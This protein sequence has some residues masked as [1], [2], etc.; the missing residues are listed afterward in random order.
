MTETEEKLK[1]DSGAEPTSSGDEKAYPTGLRLVIILATLML[2]TFLMALDSTIISVATPR[3]STHF[4][5]LDDVGWYGAAYGMTLCAFTPILSS[6]YKHFNPKVVYMAVIVIFEG[7]SASLIMPIYANHRFQLARSYALQRLPRRPSLLVEQL[8][9]W[10]Q[11][12]CCK[13]HLG[14]SRIFAT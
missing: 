3:I 7:L 8:P 5:A 4:H 2:G 11:P 1:S 12:A 13:E 6:F 14:C 9:V 10:V